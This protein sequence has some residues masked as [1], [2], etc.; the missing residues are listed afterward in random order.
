MNPTDTTVKESPLPETASVQT[1]VID[2]CTT[3][4]K[5]IKEAK[6]EILTT[7]NIGQ[8]KVSKAVKMFRPKG[9]KLCFNTGYSGRIGITEILILTP[10]VKELILSRAGEANIKQAGRQEGM[11][12]M[13]EDGLRKAL[14]ELTSLEEVMRVTAADEKL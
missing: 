11:S 10:K 7:T 1:S 3:N 2:L 13:R 5:K 14:E 4:D 12:T 9:C 8:E 6:V